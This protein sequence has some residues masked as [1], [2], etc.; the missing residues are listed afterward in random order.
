[1]PSSTANTNT[2][3]LP[4]VLMSTGMSA[5]GRTTAGTVSDSGW[6]RALRSTWKA[7]TPK[8]NGLMNTSSDAGSR[9]N[10]TFT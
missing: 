5:P 2:R 7:A 1:M 6:V 3:A 9:R 4:V 10:C 8:L